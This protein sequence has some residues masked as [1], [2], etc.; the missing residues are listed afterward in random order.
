[1]KVFNKKTN[2]EY[3]LTGDKYEA[4]LA[5]LGSEAKA[6]RMGHLDI[7]QSTVRVLNNELYLINA[8][9]PVLSP[10]KGYNPTRSRK[11]LLNKREIVSIISKTKQQKLTIVPNAVYNHG[12]LFKL[13]IALG[14][15]KRKF[16]KKESIKKKD[17]EREF[18]RQFKIE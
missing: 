13:E 8:N 18:E 2:F 12:R 4:G 5:L 17:L 1:M 15:P 14:K 9:I 7:K 16:E 6:I 10:P 11:L 3:V